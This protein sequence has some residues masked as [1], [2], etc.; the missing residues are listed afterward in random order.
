MEKKHHVVLI[1]NGRT[2]LFNVDIMHCVE[3]CEPN[4]TAFLFIAEN[5]PSQTLQALTLKVQRMIASK[6]KLNSNPILFVFPSTLY[7]KKIC[8]F[9]TFIRKCKKENITLS[10]SSIAQ[11]MFQLKAIKFIANVVKVHD[12]KIIV[13]SILHIICDTII[14]CVSVRLSQDLRLNLTLYITL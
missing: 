6:K 5:N 9:Q 3:Q 2:R 7:R 14:L 8:L 10:Q 11:E 12:E 1:V 4:K 13:V